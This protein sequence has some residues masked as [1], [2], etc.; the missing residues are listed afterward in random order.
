MR[1]KVIGAACPGVIEDCGD[2]LS[3]ALMNAGPI[4]H[5]PLITMNAAPLEHFPTAGTFT[6]KAR[7]RR[8]AASPTQLDAERIAVRE[9]L[10]YNGAAFPARRPL[11]QAK[12]TSGCTAAV[13]TI[14]LTDSGDWR[15]HIVLTQ[16][17]YMLRGHAHRA[18]RSSCRAAQLAGVETPLVKAFLAIGGAICGENFMQT[19]RTLAALGLRPS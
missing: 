8:S 9:A 6:R 12:A 1:C 19:G 16:H 7:S 13:R 4:I 11:C 15:E 18:C 2:A 10:G 14:K 17:R 5:P 3:G